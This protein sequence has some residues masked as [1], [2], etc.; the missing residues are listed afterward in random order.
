VKVTFVSAVALG[1]LFGTSTIALGNGAF[2]NSKVATLCANVARQIR[3]LGNTGRLALTAHTIEETAAVTAL[4]ALKRQLSL[5]YLDLE[6]LAGP[7]TYQKLYVDDNMRDLLR[8]FEEIPQM[9]VFPLAKRNEEVE[10][11]ETITDLLALQVF[12]N[13]RDDFHEN[14]VP[15]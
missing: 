7:K 15:N 11:I 6:V 2:G 3:D 5:D 8:M 9:R 1:T 13:C 10:K 12:G 14:G 4:E